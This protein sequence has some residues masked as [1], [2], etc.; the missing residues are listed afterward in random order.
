MNFSDINMKII[1]LGPAHP[2]RGGIATFNDRLALQFMA[3]G[4][5]VEVCTYKLQYPSFLFPGKSQF[6]DAPAPKGLKIERKLNSI[7]PLNWV[8]IGEELKRKNADLIITRLWLP[9]MVPC[10]AS[11]AWMAKNN[12]HTKVIAIL[13]N[14]IPHEKRLGDKLLTKWFLKTMDGYIA[15]SHSVL[16]DSLI[17]D[18]LK[19]RAF[20]PHP[21][22]DQYGEKLDRSLALKKINLPTDKRYM[23]FFGF[24]RDY[25]GLELLMKA[26]ADTRF[27]TLNTELIVAGEFYNNEEKYKTI[28]KEL[29]LEGKIHWYNEFIKDNEVKYFFCAA[30]IIVQPYISA[31]QSGVTQIGY[32]FEK[33]MLVTD[34]GGLAEIIPN[35]KVGYTVK[36]EADK[37][38]DALID[39]FSNKRYNDFDEGIKEEKQ[40]YS[41]DNMTDTILKTMKRT[42]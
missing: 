1:L 39:F 31:T 27:R 28:E 11:V 6:T 7:N 17:F 4:H 16:K 21:L 20:S 33:P 22:Y 14:V 5:N 13:D 3:E 38:A 24:I 23:L 41:W 29:K 15:M 19:P 40:K 36:P 32:H 10:L 25:K 37:I 34:V 26:Y 12:N 35:G 9:Y 8:I 18:K 30:D 2:Y 42:L